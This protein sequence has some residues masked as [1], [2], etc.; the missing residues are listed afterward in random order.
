MQVA[1]ILKLELPTDDPDT[2]SQAV[3]RIHSNC[4]QDDDVISVTPWSRDATQV[5][6]QLFPNVQT[7]TANPGIPPTTLL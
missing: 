3:E 2:L 7:P 1:F 4:E 5:L 6:T